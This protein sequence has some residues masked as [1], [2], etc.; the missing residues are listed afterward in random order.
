[1]K[2]VLNQKLYSVL[3]K[4]PVLAVGI[5]ALALFLHGVSASVVPPNVHQA[6]TPPVARALFLDDS[7]IMRGNWEIHIIDKDSIVGP[8]IDL[9][10]DNQS[11]AHIA[12]QARNSG[13]LNYA[14]VGIAEVVCQAVDKPPSYNGGYYPS[15]ELAANNVAHIVHLDAQNKQV[16]YVTNK[17]GSWQ[18]EICDNQGTSVTDAAERCL[19][20][21]LDSTGTPHVA[22][23]SGDSFT[24]ALKYNVQVGSNW[25]SVVLDS[26][27][28]AGW[29]PN[30][31]LTAAGFPEVIYLSKG[32]D[33]I[34]LMA[35]DGSNWTKETIVGTNI[36]GW[37]STALSNG[38]VHFCFKETGR[39][40][41]AKKN[42]STWAFETITTTTGSGWSAAFQFS[43]DGAPTVAW[44]DSEENSLQYGI[45]SS[46]GWALEEVYEPSMVECCDLEYD[47][48]GR[49]YIA[50]VNDAELWLAK[51]RSQQNIVM[52]L[53][54]QT[55]YRAG[56][57]FDFKVRIDPALSGD[58]SADLYVALEVY[59][60]F[61]FY[62]S[63]TQDLDWLRVFLSNSGS[64]L[65]PILSFTWP[66]GVGSAENLRFWALLMDPGTFTLTSN[67]DTATFSFY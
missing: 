21:A 9:E 31:Y 48:V 20:L 53:L 19:D 45:R 60:E 42:G 59:G 57:S 8:C 36:L 50:F 49:A 29:Y 63:W 22:I 54:N 58:L 6:A 61:Y 40:R 1:M 15:M 39:F 62:P 12:Y 44:V 47:K 25:Q 32:C 35:S 46:E 55:A 3:S 38:S 11:N 51:Q 27:C 17:V 7:G 33:E 37:I 4:A 65:I 26:D 5:L 28:L 16:R 10:L 18:A 34:Y 56:D 66:A 67:V 41:Y 24:S 43:G 13:S 64:Y 30:L 14:Y 52:A 2:S 23:N